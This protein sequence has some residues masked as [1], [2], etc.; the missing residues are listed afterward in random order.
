MP[1]ANPNK[2]EWSYKYYIIIFKINV[3][4][5]YKKM[6]WYIINS[7]NLKIVDNNAWPK[8]NELYL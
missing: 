8:Y 6:V 5:I 4:S 7:W 1:E 3:V 2:S